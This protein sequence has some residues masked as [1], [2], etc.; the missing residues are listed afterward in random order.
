MIHDKVRE[1][2]NVLNLPED[3]CFNMIMNNNAN[4]TI[5]Q[6]KVKK[7]YYKNALKYH[8]D[9]KPHGD[10]ERFKKINEAY[11]FLET[12]INDSINKSTNEST[13]ENREKKRSGE[14]N[15]KN[16]ASETEYT[17]ILRQ[18]INFMY[19]TNNW[20]DLFIETTF[21]SLIQ[22]CEEASLNIFRN[23]DKE[24]SCEIYEFLANSFC[25]FDV[26]N[27]ELLEKIRKICHDKMKDD[28]I[29]IL[30]PSVEDLMVDNIYKFNIG[31]NDYY[32]PLWHNKLYFDA[33]GND[34]IVLIK[35]ELPENME[36]DHNNN[37]SVFIEHDIQDIFKNKGCNVDVGGKNFFI[38]NKQITFDEKCQTFTFVKSGPALIDTE[39][40]FNTMHRSKIIIYL[41][42]KS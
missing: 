40:M 19:P 5:I 30:T 2:C 8:P 37:I 28:N 38:E 32:A 4:K 26:Q 24:K 13:K 36:I 35:P 6:E 39:N 18:A 42:L 33:S 27:K 31:G 22:T 20:D 17:N 7:A 1:A 14:S 29:I 12:T 15:N 9:K 10:A 34:I 11:E 3:E 21:N 41:T 23:M 16:N 25:I